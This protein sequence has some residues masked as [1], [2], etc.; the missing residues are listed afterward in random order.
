MKAHYRWKFAQPNIYT[1]GSDKAI[2]IVHVMVSA[3]SPEESLQLAQTL[4]DNYIGFVDMMT[5]DRAI[6]HYLISS[7]QTS[8]FRKTP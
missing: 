1:K 2:R 5:K 4:F 7:A 6:E 3:G 8:L